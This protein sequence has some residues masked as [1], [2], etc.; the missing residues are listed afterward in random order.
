MCCC[1][2]K[3]TTQNSLKPDRTARRTIEAGKI[4]QNLR[5]H[6]PQ[7]IVVEDSTLARASPVSVNVRNLLR[8]PDAP[9][10]KAEEQAG[11]PRD[12]PQ[13]LPK[14]DTESPAPISS[15]VDDAEMF[16]EQ[17]LD[18]KSVAIS[19]PNGSVS[20]ETSAVAQKLASPKKSWQKNGNPGTAPGA[21]SSQN[22]DHDTAISSSRAVSS[23]GVDIASDQ[24]DS[25]ISPSPIQQEEQY[26][27]KKI[28]HE[29]TLDEEI[30]P[31]KP[32][33][34]PVN[35]RASTN[36]HSEA[37][38]T[39]KSQ[40]ENSQDLESPQIGATLLRR[41][42]LR[43]K[44]SPQR[45]AIARKSRSPQ[46]R[47]GLKKRDTLQ[48]RE[49]LQQF[50][51]AVSPSQKIDNQDLL[52]IKGD[53]CPSESAPDKAE[54]SKDPDSARVPVPG[55][56]DH[57]SDHVVASGAQTDEAALDEKIMQ[58]T[59]LQRA[60]EAIEMCKTSKSDMPIDAT[61]DILSSSILE[62][63]DTLNQA[64]AYIA[65][66]EMEQAA[67]TIATV[68]DKTDLPNRKTRSGARFSDDTTMLK[69]FLNR[70]QARKA[71]KDPPLLSTD[72]P[73]PHPSPR[74]TPR[75]AL[76]PQT[77]NSQ[78]PP[79]SRDIS[80]RAGTPP[81]KTKIDVGDSDDVDDI[82]NEPVSCR[83][84]TRTRLP[85]PS[86]TPPGAP[87]FIPVRRAD[88]ADPVVIQRSQAQEL[89]TV[90]RTNTRR[91]KG[92]SKPP[93]LALQ[94]LPADSP[95]V[96]MTATQ[97]AEHAKT[98]AW[99]EQLATYQDT[100]ETAAAPDDG[101]DKRPK[102]RRMRGL[103][104]VNGTPGPKRTT[105]ATTA[106]PVSTSNGT[107]APKRRGKIR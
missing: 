57:Y 83:R 41:E 73:K 46:K 34:T 68:C 47:Q 27:L 38:P 19:P 104:A 53:H 30:L 37:T 75:A 67:Q 86:K 80:H 61:Q 11:L 95:E 98:V 15:K 65:N 33:A 107:P 84:S 101:D 103:G 93:P 48:E 6:S 106:V 69:E 54:S 24:H 64:N 23:A 26:S 99:A 29:T 44:G 77:G 42:S 13:F 100:K 25:N 97:R 14:S 2:G 71:A 4:A 28:T 16:L 45:I 91:N 32:P 92:Q 82:A 60:V 96:G 66:L 1:A 10:D 85:A 36:Q 18:G 88:G 50:S 74:R 63:D 105:T 31:G 62:P 3:Y 51:A 20:R 43:R 58:N 35:D 72:V 49:I 22:E 90:T 5:S 40:T 94:D 76:T 56:S 70:A 87:S 81:R 17:A 21:V 78:S 9:F 102:V 79:K 89:A 39:A 59:D 8:S 55:I 12:V 7:K 52:D